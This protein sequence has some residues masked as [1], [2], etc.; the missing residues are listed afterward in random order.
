MIAAGLIT[1]SR[2]AIWRLTAAGLGCR[3]A[4]PRLLHSADGRQAGRRH[5]PAHARAAGDG[6]TP[7]INWEPGE[8]DYPF[9]AVPGETA[10]DYFGR[11][12]EQA[13]LRPGRAGRRPLHPRGRRRERGEPHHRGRRAAACAARA[14]R[15]PGRDGRGLRRDDRPASSARWPSLGEALDTLRESRPL[16]TRDHRA[17]GGPTM[18]VLVLH[19]VNLDMLGKRDPGH[20]RDRHARADRRR[21]PGARRGAR[22]RGRVLPV[23]RRRRAVRADPPR[24]RRRRRGRHQ[25]RRLDPLQLRRSAMRSRS[26]ACRS[27]RSTCR[28]ST[29]GS[30]SGTTRSS[31]TSRRARSPA[32]AWTATSWAFAPRSPRRSAAEAS[33][34]H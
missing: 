3:P 2:R 15:R 10:L 7:G 23:Q 30:R 27:S 32:S 8:E 14:I 13:P 19:G 18:K 24:T 28:T 4:R 31:R 6:T 20:V 21:A 17:H 12:L 34:E 22:R 11:W 33:A 5:A 9:A 1:L 16:M 25:R 29:P 26:C